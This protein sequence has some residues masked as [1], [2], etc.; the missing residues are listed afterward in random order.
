[1]FDA[2]FITKKNNLQDLDEQLGAA[3]PF[4]FQTQELIVEACSAFPLWLDDDEMSGDMM[5]DRDLENVLR[6]YMLKTRCSS[7]ED[8]EQFTNALGWLETNA[9]VQ[10]S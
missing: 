9:K 8:K 3:E 6:N 7:L 4:C 2:L 1:M 5:H 10:D